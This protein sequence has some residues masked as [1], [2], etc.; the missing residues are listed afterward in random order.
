MART[1]EPARSGHNHLSEDTPS[2]E[3]GLLHHT[4]G[5]W[6]G[7]LTILLAC[8]MLPWSP[9]VAWQQAAGTDMFHA[10]WI[11]ERI[12]FDTTPIDVAIIGSSRMEAAISP[13]AMEQDLAPIRNA[14]GRPLS[15]A[16]L[17]LVRPGRDLH[18]LIVNDLLRWHPE[19]RMILLSDDG[20]MISSHPVFGQAASLA[21]I[22]ASPAIINPSYFS[23][24][25][26]LPYRN[27]LNALG[28]FTPSCCGIA[29]RF[30]ATTYLGSHLD[31]TTGYVL[32]SGQRRNG[33]QTMPPQAL[34]QDAI[35]VLALQNA[36]LIHRLSFLPEHNRY[37]VDRHY[38]PMI[39]DA[40]RKQGVS[41]AFVRLPVYGQT[42]LAGEQHYYQQ[43]GPVFDLTD[44]ANNSALFQDGLHMNQLGA[45]VESQRLAQKIRPLVCR[46]SE[47]AGC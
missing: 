21:Q 17:S 39:A 12:H 20:D 6:I 8:M 26:A 30:D 29:P 45:A 5:F 22:A 40:A 36:G 25:L 14:T 10:R 28:Q 11:Y 44:V 3:S 35:A 24:L 4:V 27:L 2:V 19:V 31:R 47:V 33:M 18:S 42:Q 41:I 46:H 13:A 9:Y 1:Q 16:N 34:A 23:H 38:V 43:F 32:P 7:A 37:A 15:I